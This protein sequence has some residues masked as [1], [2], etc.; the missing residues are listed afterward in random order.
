M[1]LPNETNHRIN[2]TF[3]DWIKETHFIH[4]LLNLIYNSL[5]FALFNYFDYRHKV[6]SCQF[7]FRVDFAFVRF[8]PRNIVAKECLKCFDA[9]P[10]RCIELVDLI[11]FKRYNLRIVH[12]FR[13][14]FRRH[15]QHQLKHVNCYIMILEISSLMSLLDPLWLATLFSQLF[16]PFT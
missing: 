11:I 6:L 3:V 13:L 15:F 5:Y 2:S 12:R 16:K 7:V 4:D 8:R 10:Y 14:S 1:T 9:L